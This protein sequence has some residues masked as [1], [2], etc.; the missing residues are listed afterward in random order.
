VPCAVCPPVNGH[1]QLRGYSKKREQKRK[2]RQE[3]P[4]PRKTGKAYANRKWESGDDKKRGGKR[5]LRKKDLKSREQGKAGQK[6]EGKR[7]RK[8]KGRN[9]SGFSP[10]AGNKISRKKCIGQ[11]NRERKGVSVLNCQEGKEKMYE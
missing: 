11:K 1:M 9:L 10:D 6:R 3:I 2:S 8:K 5:I 7:S 4:E